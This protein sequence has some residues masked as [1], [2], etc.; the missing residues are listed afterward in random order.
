MKLQIVCSFFFWT[1]RPLKE[2]KEKDKII[3]KKYL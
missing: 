1:I 2:G 3:K